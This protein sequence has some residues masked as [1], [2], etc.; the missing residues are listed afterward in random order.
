MVPSFLFLS[1]PSLPIVVASQRIA[2]RK[3]E[4]TEHKARG[5]HKHPYKHECGCAIHQENIYERC[6]GAHC[7]KLTVD[8]LESSISTLSPFCLFLSLTPPFP[9]TN[10]LL[11]PRTPLR[12]PSRFHVSRSPCYFLLRRRGVRGIRTCFA[13]LLPSALLFRTRY[14]TCAC[15]R[16]CMHER[17]RARVHKL[18]LIRRLPDNVSYIALD[19]LGNYSRT[20]RCGL[21]SR[22]A[23]RV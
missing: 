18:P 11:K 5:N 3:R 2:T 14:D 20:C 6:R 17:E 10:S 23:V 16:A 1:L 9:S 4:T 22:F 7:Y 12:A 8:S 19:E 21:V 13:F 15:M